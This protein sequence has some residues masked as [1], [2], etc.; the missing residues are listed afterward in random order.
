MWKQGPR[1]KN[2]R[3]WQHRTLSL[4]RTGF[5]RFFADPII[6]GCILESGTHP[7]LMAPTG[8][9]QDVSSAGSGRKNYMHSDFGYFEEH[10]LGK[11]YDFKLETPVPVLQTL[12]VI[13]SLL[14]FSVIV[15]R[16]E[17]VRFHILPKSSTDT[18]PDSDSTEKNP[19]GE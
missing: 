19:P 8:T 14:D 4:S 7:E 15:I 11:P 6:R 2:I 5:R 3:Q 18:F 17:T 12:S 10:A 16:L 13:A 9:T 1:C